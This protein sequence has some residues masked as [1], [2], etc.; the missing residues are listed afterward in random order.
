MIGMV[1]KITSACHVLI[2]LM[3]MCCQH[4]GHR[5]CTHHLQEVNRIVGDTT[6][7]IN[8]RVPGC[9]HPIPY[10]GGCILLVGKAA[11]A[12]REQHRSGSWVL[13]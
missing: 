9:L 2:M 10:G 8:E 12:T 6:L 1:P 13:T 3:S 4:Q 11:H 7:T 5:L